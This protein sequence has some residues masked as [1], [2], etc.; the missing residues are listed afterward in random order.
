E[1][2]IDGLRLDAVHAIL[3]LSAVHFLEEL[4]ASVHQYAEVLGRRVY[5]IAESDLNDPRL[6]KP[7]AV[8]GYGLDAQWSDD[9]HHALHALLTGER[10]G[11][12]QD[13]GALRH[14]ARAF[15]NGYVYTGQ[16]SNYRKRR[17]G[18]RTELCTPDQFVV[19]AQ[20]HD[21]VGNR[22][23]G[24]RLSVLV[25]FSA[26][27]L[28]AGLVLLSP[29]LPLLFMGEEYGE[30]A[31]FQYFTSHSDAALAE[32]VR[33]GRREEFAAFGWQNNV[34]DPQDEETFIRSR[35]RRELL[36][37]EQHKLLWE[38][39][40]NLIRLR[41]ESPALSNLDR[42]AMEVTVCE[43]ERLLFVRRWHSDDE[44]WLAFSFNENPVTV[45][46]PLPPRRW[47]KMVD[48]ADEQW[49]GGG[50]MVPAELVSPGE[51]ALTL[52]PSACVLLAR[53]KE[54]ED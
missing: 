27:K 7:R 24:E 25:S 42:D 21:Q 41:R 20:N 39:Y 22:A 47:R 50:S 36:R 14:L 33:K 5:V 30:T 31:P 37:L 40:R 49:L 2:H 34:P 13:F 6:I 43:R 11:Y 53:T 48:S 23:C 52:S 44:V 35:L 38:F 46:L 9:F 16:Y 12:Y 28:A 17:H 32:A 26:L 54:V 1:F 18:N 29:F 15:T 45:T 8:G 10:S 3:D 51:V 19:F 4:A